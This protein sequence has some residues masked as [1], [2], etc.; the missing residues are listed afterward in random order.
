MKTFFKDVN[1]AVAAG[2]PFDEQAF[3][4]KITDYEYMW[5]RERIGT[6][7]DEP[8]GDGIALARNIIDKY[9]A[10]LEAKYRK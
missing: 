3:R 1:A 8:E 6:F 5:W 9:R 4:T 2:K 7:S 10:D